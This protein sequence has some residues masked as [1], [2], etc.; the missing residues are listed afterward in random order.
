[1][2]AFHQLLLWTDARFEFAHEDIVRRQQIPMSPEELFAD[3]EQFLEGVREH[4]GQLSPSTVLEQNVQRVQQFGKQVP[5]EVHGILRMFDGHRVLADILED[6]PYRVFETLR[7][8]QKAVEIGLL[9]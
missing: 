9:R 3:A 7:V 4:A 5:T 2:A 6:S 8:T 1:Q